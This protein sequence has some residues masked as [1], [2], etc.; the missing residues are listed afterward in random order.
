MTEAIKQQAASFVVAV[1]CISATNGMTRES[2]LR[3]ARLQVWRE[4]TD[5]DLGLV[6]REL[7]DKRMVI[8]A[9]SS[10]GPAR[11]RITDHGRSVAREEGLA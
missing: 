1:L 11:Y 8:D 4:L 6:L 10:L 5:A 7:G 9:P 2:I 3:E